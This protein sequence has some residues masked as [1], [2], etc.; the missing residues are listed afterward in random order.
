MEQTEAKHEQTALDNEGH[1]RKAYDEQGKLERALR[2]ALSSAQDG[3][4]V[5]LGLVDAVEAYEKARGSL[6]S[7]LSMPSDTR[8]AELV[9]VVEN[10]RCD[11]L[12][13]FA[14]VSNEGVEQRWFE[15]LRAEAARLI[16]R[17]EAHQ[18]VD[19]SSEDFFVSLIELHESA[20]AGEVNQSLLNTLVAATPDFQTAI[21]LIAAGT[22]PLPDAE[23]GSDQ[24]ES[25][26][27]RPQ[28]KSGSETQNRPARS[29]R[30]QDAEVRQAGSEET[31]EE[32]A[33]H[34][35]EAA[36]PQALTT[37]IEDSAASQTTAERKSSPGTDAHDTLPSDAV[38]DRT[39][40]QQSGAKADALARETIAEL[41][42]Q[43]RFGLAFQ[44]AR[45][46]PFSGSEGYARVLE[47]AAYADGIASGMG[48]TAEPLREQAQELSL[49]SRL[50]IDRPAQLLAVAA[51]LRVAAI[52]PHL[53]SDQ[54]LA[55]LGAGIGEDAPELQQLC[56]AVQHLAAKG[57]SISQDLV[58]QHRDAVALELRR[59]ELREHAQALISNP[60]TINYARATA[61]WRTMVQSHDQ[62][63][64]SALRVVQEDDRHARDRV[65]ETVTRLRNRKTLDTVIDEHDRLQR[66]PSVKRRI[67]GAA[68][69]SLRLRILEVVDLTE[70]WVQ[71]DQNLER[72]EQSRES[73]WLRQ[74]GEEL[75]RAADTIR[76]S[77]PSPSWPGDDEMIRAVGVAFRK[78]AD[79]VVGLALDAK[80]QPAQEYPAELHL[81]AE[82]LRDATIRVDSRLEPVAGVDLGKL[83]ALVSEPDWTRAYQVRAERRDHDLLPALIEL[84]RSQDA[85]AATACEERS[86]LLLAEARQYYERRHLAVGARLSS[87]YQRGALKPE[88]W[89]LWD[90]ERERLALQDDDLAIGSKLDDLERLDSESAAQAAEMVEQRA[91]ELRAR[92]PDNVDREV[93]RRL[94]LALSAS[95]VATAEEVL[96]AHERDEP[97]PLELRRDPMLEKW[98]PRVSNG[99]ADLT[100]PRSLVQSLIRGDSIYDM[101]PVSFSD[102]QEKI[103]MAAFS[104]WG[105]LRAQDDR[106]VA[107]A[108]KKVLRLL[109]LDL[110]ECRP[111]RTRA[112]RDARQYGIDARLLG[113]ALLPHF[114]SKAKGS[115]LVMLLADMDVAPDRLIGQLEAR[116]TAD[117][118]LLLYT[119][120]LS[121]RQRQQFADLTRTRRSESQPMLIDLATLVAVATLDPGRFDACERATLP[122]TGLN[123]YDPY[124][125]GLVP[126]EIFYGRREQLD[127][128][129]SR[130]GSLA[131]IYGGRRLGKSAL[132]RAAERE[133]PIVDG[134][135]IA[136][137]LDL[138]NHGIGHSLR[139][140][141]LLTVIEQQLDAELPRINA[142][143]A[144][145]EPAKR[146]I[147]R[148]K[149]L[150][151]GDE[152]ARVL[153]LL[154][155]CDLFIAADAKTNFSTMAALRDL[156]EETDK[157]FRPI[158]AGLHNVR[159]FDEVPNQRNV[160]FGQSQSVGPLMPVDARDLIERPLDA[161]GYRLEDESVHRIL[162]ITQHQPSLIQLVCDELV[163]HMLGKVRM[164]DTPPY[165]ISHQDVEHVLAFPSLAR[166]IAARFDLTIALDAR[167]R[168][169]ALMVAYL[170]DD[171]A[172]TMG[173]DAREL[174]AN[175][176]DFWASGFLDT[177]YA[178]FESL[179]QEMTALGV[180]YERNGLYSLRS[181]HV[182]RMLGTQK[183]IED[184]LLAAAS[185]ERAATMFDGS[186][187]RYEMPPK[188]GEAIGRRR[189]PL[190]LRQTEDLLRE[191]DGIFTIVG[192]PALGSDVIEGA[193]VALPERAN[194]CQYVDAELMSNTASGKR[195]LRALKRET[196]AV[197]R[198]VSI[199]CHTANSDLLGKSIGQAR[200]TLQKR[201][202]N[203][204]SACG[205]ILVDETAVETWRMLN[206][207]W[208][209]SGTR[210]PVR[211]MELQR[212]NADGLR[213]WLF[214]QATDLPALLDEDIQ[215][216]LE[217]TGGWPILVDQFVAGLGTHRQVE[218]ELSNA[219]MRLEDAESADSFVRST[220]V[221]SDAEVQ[222]GFTR[223]L[224]YGE[225][226]V[227]VDGV[228]NAIA[229]ICDRPPV[230]A[231]A[232]FEA[233]RGL[234]L[235][236]IDG[237][238]SIS[239]EPVLAAAWLASA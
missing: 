47:F 96:L 116:G 239:C 137:Y 30:G 212:W 54:V 207:Q 88:Q 195:F 25:A 101:P 102:D 108:L 50:D 173:F 229:A 133:A 176:E 33:V 84:I 160:H 168:L 219:R 58:D 182:A 205:V 124:A 118:T 183:Q 60:G 9:D 7:R 91:G 217:A 222:H 226:L 231:E 140:E 146:L 155:E 225:P 148:V 156:Q 113:D 200:K 32:V 73:A 48:P 213:S 11:A 215:R 114:G 45:I 152:K 95:D 70:Q 55:K 132:L 39:G 78:I 17:R 237:K 67:E 83:A 23:P 142:A 220:A 122:F 12:H 120:V 235:V 232:V 224:E 154:D 197:H 109:G 123:P 170:T 40:G 71:I 22:L 4:H 6:A 191:V 61:L 159:R 35:A 107:A 167:Y 92:L 221:R 24:T 42:S 20:V 166:E 2:A 139:P 52:A 172:M 112:A 129:L 72:L 186:S 51:A 46:V 38:A 93:S 79:E 171:R 5:A 145:S 190:T 236:E 100:D 199:R 94:E 111:T 59:E 150:L 89:Q 28:C 201:M 147:L 134:N 136:R 227:P 157:R 104:A 210:L 14:A 135:I 218:A 86:D 184:R 34:S 49:D 15:P 164:P 189:S 53:G 18:A 77:E 119:G 105:D 178:E 110:T 214:D 223:L 233:L 85:A 165:K 36:R 87:S 21:A 175:C 121:P 44:V 202:P 192:S 82:L 106:R 228:V 57:I 27:P 26:D 153:L 76:N 211:V 230:V 203:V 141:N 98:Y 181:P 208:I 8:L 125:S 69:E 209:G 68:R 193:L 174:K 37:A 90:I 3:A 198:I 185:E 29:T 64:A 103:V 19:P 177:D 234:R 13:R 117:P 216:L 163:R 10:S 161:L 238:G 115:Y 97:L 149:E 126:P 62:D 144:R 74:A 80:Y 1:V 151:A 128:L 169:I 130:D 162:T 188:D 81:G 143:K 180:L 31:S 158:F 99:L 196:S 16:A 43:R 41:I 179:L 131:F 138:G 63:L 56:S 127:D 75:R 206:E 187:Y 65:A 66:R 194:T 204:G